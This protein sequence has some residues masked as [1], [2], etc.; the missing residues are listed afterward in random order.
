MKIQREE[1]IDLS[2]WDG[3]VCNTCVPKRLMKSTLA[4]SNAISPFC[5]ISRI[6]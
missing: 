2:I 5:V 1:A 6:M 4:R 3:G